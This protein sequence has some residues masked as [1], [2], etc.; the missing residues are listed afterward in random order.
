MFDSEHSYTGPYREDAPDLIIG[1]GKNYRASWDS[2]V[3]RVTSKV[4]EDNCKAWSGD[5][6]IDP[7]LVPGVLFCNRRI[8]QEQAAIVD[9]AP[10]VLD[11][12]GVKPPANLDGKTLNMVL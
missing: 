8:A 10:T 2:V 11:L 9:L 3:G 4:F 12:F 6:C 5:H 1:Y 7:N